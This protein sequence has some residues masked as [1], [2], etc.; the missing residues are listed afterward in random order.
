M[1]IHIYMYMHAIT[2]DD[3]GSN[4][5]EVELEKLGGL[6]GKKREGGML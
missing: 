6:S 2:I 4:A 1:R 3:K 5:F